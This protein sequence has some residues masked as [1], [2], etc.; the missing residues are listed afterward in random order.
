MIELARVD[1]IAGK[2]AAATLKKTG[3]SRVFSAPIVDLDG[4]EALSVTVV[5]KSGTSAKVKGD[6]AF[7]TI[8]RIG[9]DLS[10]AGDDRLAVVHFATEEELAAIGDP[11]S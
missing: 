1:E 5:L 11:E 7:D 3:I 10:L 9:Q 2:A 8:V 4:K 6:A